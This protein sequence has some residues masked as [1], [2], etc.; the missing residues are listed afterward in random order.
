MKQ[1]KINAILG[2]G[3]GQCSVY[4]IYLVCLMAIEENSLEPL[5]HSLLPL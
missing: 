4:L 1:T 3:E 5:R 2:E